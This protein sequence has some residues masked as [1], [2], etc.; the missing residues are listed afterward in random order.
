MDIGDY[1]FFF[2]FVLVIIGRVL[3][4]V[5][6][7]I[8]EK[9]SKTN[10]S[11]SKKPGIIEQVVDWFKEIEK[12]I[13]QQNSPE[14]IHDTQWEELVSQPVDSELQPTPQLD[15]EEEPVL[16]DRRTKT[17]EKKTHKRPDLKNNTQPKKRTNRKRINL[18]NAIIHYEMIGP[19]LALRQE[20]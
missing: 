8:L 9:S 3:S 1:I 14:L 18:R 19:P 17:V 10:N 12:N 11:P 2:F 7:I 20:H 16:N 5:F 13:V 4:W 15:F 6:K